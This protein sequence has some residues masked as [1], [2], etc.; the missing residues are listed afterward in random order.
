MMATVFIHRLAAA[1]LAEYWAEVDVHSEDSAFVKDNPEN[2]DDVRRC[3]I[4]LERALDKQKRAVL[5][6]ELDDRAVKALL[7]EA[8]DHMEAARDHFNELHP[9]LEAEQSRLAWKLT[10]AYKQ[11]VKQLTR[12]GVDA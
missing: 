2:I 3:C 6:V 9:G 4:E 7:L 8:V 5:A 11:L 1:D 10:R 12:L